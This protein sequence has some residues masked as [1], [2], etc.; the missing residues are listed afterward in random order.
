MLAAPNLR[1][2]LAPAAALALAACGFDDLGAPP[3][4]GLARPESLF[5]PDADEQVCA[6]GPAS[7]APHP[8]LLAADRGCDGLAFCARLG[9]DLRAVAA[10]ADPRLALQRSAEAFARFSEGGR[11][12]DHRRARAFADLA[13]SGGRA[14]AAFA[15]W[16][17]QRPSEV[18]GSAEETAKARALERAYRVAWA[19][20]GPPSVR[21]ALRPAL[22]YVAVSSE[23]D[24]PHRPVNVVSPLV[25]ADL[26]MTVEGRAGRPIALRVRV[27]QAS[28]EPLA[29]TGAPAVGLLPEEPLRLPAHGPVL[30]SVHGHASLAEEAVALFP[31]LVARA[32]ADGRPLTVIAVDLPSNAYSTHVDYTEVG[33]PAD[34]QAGLRFLDRFLIELVDALEARQPGLSERIEAVMGGSLGGNLVLRLAEREPAPSWVRRVVAWSP[35]SV[36]YSWSRARVAFPAPGSEFLDVVKHEAVRLTRDAS[37]DPEEADSRRDY[38]LSGLLGV[39]TQADY[40]YRPD[41]GCRDALVIEGMR[42]LSEVYEPRFRRWHYRIA[43]EQLVFSHIERGDDGR[44]PFERIRVPLLL[45]AG[46]DDN[47]V[48]MQT[49]FFL[50][51]LAPHLTMPGE[52]VFLQATGHAMHSERPALM[53]QLLGAFLWGGPV[54]GGRRRPLGGGSGG[55]RREEALVLR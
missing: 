8:D 34:A 19:L 39:R 42:Q 1:S 22:G 26:A 4:A 45:L 13:V 2:R 18:P 46:E 33:D 24:L 55:G 54:E 9:A 35:A 3:E 15:R 20:R 32:R 25:Q 10:A 37:D 14:Y 27:A 12:R 38:F 29:S 47:G 5:L 31:A 40:W 52:T 36:D 28:S 11:D 41:W 30:L 50:E 7:H 17:P 48:P 51:R 23:D 43:H 44:R 49:H 53:A 16:R 21:L 6:T